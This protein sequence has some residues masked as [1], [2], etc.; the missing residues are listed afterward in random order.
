[1]STTTT[2]VVQL[3]SRLSEYL[4]IGHLAPGGNPDEALKAAD[5]A[6]YRTKPGRSGRPS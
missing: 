2:N 1:M 6:M 4:R 3:K 5:E